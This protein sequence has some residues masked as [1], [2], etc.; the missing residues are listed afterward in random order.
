MRERLRKI[1]EGLALRPGLLCVKPEMVGITQHAFEEQHG[2]IQFFRAGLTGARQGL[3]EP[4][5]AHVE[6]TFLARKSIDTGVRRVAVHKTV[7][8]ETT[9]A[10]ALENGIYCAEHARIV[11]GHKENKG[12]NQ[13]RRIQILASVE[14]RE[15]APL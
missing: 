13:E 12:H 11:R 5:G 2:L 7:A 6:G 4:E 10:G 3:H 14:L 15:R 8:D 1:A 9:L